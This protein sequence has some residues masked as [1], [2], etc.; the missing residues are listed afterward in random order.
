MTM[1]A[2]GHRFAGP[3]IC[4]TCGRSAGGQRR[5]KTAARGYGS[6]HQALRAQLTPAVQSGNTTCTRCGKTIQPGEPWD[7]DHRD[8][9]DGWLGPA[10]RRC[11][12]SNP[13]FLSAK[14]R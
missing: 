8:D 14:T 11:N 3:G 1:C 5:A 10:H 13:V 2:A 6:H 4:P 12:R 9:R 7:L